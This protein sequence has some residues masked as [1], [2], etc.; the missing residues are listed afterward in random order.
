MTKTSEVVEV[1]VGDVF[2][3]SWGYDQT[4]VCFYQ[5]TG[6][7]PSG[8]SA[9][10]RRIESMTVEED[11][12][13]EMRVP[14][15]DHFVGS[16]FTKRIMNALSAFSAPYFRMASFEYAFPWS[17]EAKYASGPYGGH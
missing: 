6:L 1:R 16:E 14:K 10:L 5:V 17:G 7:T 15:L 2:V 8:K 13:F 4:N 11:P 3:S 9:R 12:T